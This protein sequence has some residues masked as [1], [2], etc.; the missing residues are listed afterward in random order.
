[1]IPGICLIGISGFANIYYDYFIR[2]SEAGRVKLLA[3]TIIN[4][5]E[6]E[7]KCAHLKSIG[8]QLFDDYH[9]MLEAMSGKAHLCAVP[10]GIYLHAPMTIA[11][12]K[13]GIN[14]LVEKPAAATVQEVD[15]MLS[16]EKESGC[17]TAVGFQHMYTKETRKMKEIIL[18]GKIGN[19][20]TIKSM[21][22][23][24]RSEEYFT[25]NNWTGKLK[26]GEHWVLDSP[27]QNANAHMINLMCFLAGVTYERTGTLVS[28]QGEMARANKIESADTVG[29][30]IRTAE[31]IDILFY[32][33]LAAESIIDSRV[34]ICGEKGAL[35]WDYHKSLELIMKDGSSEIF[36]V[37]DFNVAR[38]KAIKSVLERL[39]NPGRFICTLSYAR[40]QVL[41]V[42]ALHTASPICDVPPDLV[43]TFT[44]GN[45]KYTKI[46]GI[47]DI[48]TNAFNREM[49]L[50]ET[51]VDW[52]TAGKNLDVREYHEFT[53]PLGY[54]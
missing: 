4:Q 46:K 38:D 54:I 24:I 30:K 25:K 29:L 43:H 36:E 50:S 41:A 3:A 20:K 44:R 18:S 7:K 15:A 51:G 22:L 12:L 10:T 31:G 11:A 49:L 19:I 13:K 1:M 23:W 47:N 52:I 35:S 39:E 48:I 34:V 37:D 53:R 14:V 2:E 17:F 45:K 40:N 32:S 6:E 26:S 42:N 21:T 33:S 9:K 27:A 28:I 8:C 16:A 5:D